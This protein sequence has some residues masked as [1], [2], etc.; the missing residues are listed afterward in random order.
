M[1]PTR[2]GIAFGLLAWCMAW[3]VA[4]YGGL[5]CHDFGGSELLVLT[6][7]GF[8]GV[9]TALTLAHRFHADLVQRWNAYAVF[10]STFFV[11]IYTPIMVLAVSGPY[12][13]WA[14]SQTRPPR[15]DILG[16]I[17][18]RTIEQIGWVH[19]S[20]VA[21][22]VAVCLCATTAVNR[23]LRGSRASWQTLA[24]GFDRD[25]IKLGFVMIVASIVVI[26][27]GARKLP[28]IL[29]TVNTVDVLGLLCAWVLIWLLL[30]SLRLQR[31][32]LAAQIPFKNEPTVSRRAGLLGL[33]LLV[34]PLGLL[35]LF[36]KAWDVRSAIPF[37]VLSAIVGLCGVI[38]FRGAGKPAAE[39]RRRELHIAFFMTR[40]GAWSAVGCALLIG[41]LVLSGIARSQI[42]KAPQVATPVA[43][44]IL[45]TKPWYAAAAILAAGAFSGAFVFPLLLPRSARA[46]E[47]VVGIM[48]A[49]CVVGAVTFTLLSL[50]AL[51]LALSTVPF[52]L[53]GRPTF[54]LAD[55]MTQRIAEGDWTV[56][57]WFYL[58]AFLWSA[59]FA[60]VGWGLGC[61]IDNG[62]E[63][64]GRRAIRLWRRLTGR[65][66]AQ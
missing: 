24:A 35:P 53:A 65:D 17:L 2:V 29:S 48:R 7:S 31:E 13:R 66:G 41:G 45:A 50:Y 12:H 6:A 1:I 60:A 14:L 43:L 51:N 54:T 20:G 55:R 64:A 22:L 37:L 10:A 30:R 39:D 47:Q 11:A 59:A 5:R 33:V 57:S 42:E 9:A 18:V 27:V 19:W 4:R 21:A 8:V 38:Y 52:L 46:T 58:G 15:R 56:L 3:L 32:E 61:L 49:G 26:A 36:L 44:A 62:F 28:A 25:D 40:L 16:E 23:S 34:I 63:W